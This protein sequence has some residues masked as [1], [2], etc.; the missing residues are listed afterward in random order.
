MSYVPK[1]NDYVK[2][3]KGKFSVEGWIYFMDQSYLT[4]EI[5]V[6]CIHLVLLGHH[7]SVMPSLHFTHFVFEVLFH[8]P[9]VLASGL[10]E[11]LKILLVLVNLCHLLIELV[12]QSSGCSKLLLVMLHDQF[13]YLYL[14]I[15]Q[16]HESSVFGIQL[17]IELSELTLFNSVDILWRL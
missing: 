16:S 14:F 10:L 7:L 3:N 11:S 9:L 15:L 8:R 5:G 6:K 4:I 17:N 12:L 1:L 2:W 13:G